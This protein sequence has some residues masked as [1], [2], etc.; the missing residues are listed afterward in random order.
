MLYRNNCV[1]IFHSENAEKYIL[2]KRN[3]N[4][5]AKHVFTSME[6]GNNVIYHKIAISKMYRK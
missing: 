3:D 2:H 1:H 6:R 5:I 4:N